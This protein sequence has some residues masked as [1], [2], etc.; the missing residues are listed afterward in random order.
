MKLREPVAPPT[1]SA[2]SLPTASAAPAAETPAPLLPPLPELI[3]Q[4][5]DWLAVE[6]RYSGNTL[7]AYR[8]DLALLSQ[9]LADTP[10]TE[11]TPPQTRRF[12]GRLHASGLSGKSLARVLSAWRG[13]FRFIARKYRVLLNPV[14]GIRAPK[15][16]KK[17]PHALSPDQMAQ[18]LQPADDDA[19]S[20]RDVAMFELFY[21]SGLRLSELAG[22]NPDAVDFA[23]GEVR[24]LGKGNK[25]RIV[26]VGQQALTALQQWLPLRN[27]LAAADELALFV[28]QRGKRLSVRAIQLRLQQQGLKQGISQRAHPHALR[29]SFASHVLQSSGDLRAVQEMLGHASI[30]TTQIYTHLD[31]QYLAKSYD[32]AHPRAKRKD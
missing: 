30:T 9:Q 8:H 17:L 31:F 28:G 6:R 7:E 27:S 32:A 16:A 24:V 11:L 15:A 10:L 26:P 14:V 1:G 21:S 19:L 12:V 13:L 4:Y 29:H 22:L 23:G 25:S 20:V 2:G 3:G 5:L 18:L